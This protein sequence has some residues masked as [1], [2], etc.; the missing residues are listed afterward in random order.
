MLSGYRSATVLARGLEKY[1]SSTAAAGASWL[2]AQRS[3]CG[4]LL[5]GSLPFGPSLYNTT[6]YDDSCLVFG[7]CRWHVSTRSGWMTL[8]SDCS[9]SSHSTD[10]GT[11]CPTRWASLAGNEIGTCKIGLDIVTPLA[12]LD[13]WPYPEWHT[14]GPINQNGSY[15]RTCSEFLY[16]SPPQVVA[17]VRETCAQSLGVALRHMTESGVTKTVDILLKLLTEDQW[18]VRHGGLLGIKYALAVRQV[19]YV[20]RDGRWRLIKSPFPKSW[21]L[22]GDGQSLNSNIAP[23]LERGR[24]LPRVFLLVVVD[25][26]SSL[27]WACVPC[28]RTWSRSCCPGSCLPSPRACRTWMMT[29]GRWL[30]PHSSPWWR[31]LYSCC[32]TRSSQMTAPPVSHCTS[33]LP[34]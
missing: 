22:S 15:Y 25:Y 2:E 5:F 31:A 1:S 21:H 4:N 27:C 16:P 10:L 24:S 32:R 7:V 33:A 20:V 23:P 17:P 9:A 26:I 34:L 30:P 28:P 11:L 12:G 8:W 29:S 13:G 6:W 18:E 3:R 14:T 19:P